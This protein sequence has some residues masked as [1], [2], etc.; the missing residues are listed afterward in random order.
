MEPV[1]RKYKDNP[2]FLDT[3]AWLDYRM[4]DYRSAKERLASL[5]DKK[6]LLPVINYHLGMICYRLGEE[7]QARKYLDMAINAERDFP[8][9]DVALMVLEGLNQRR[10]K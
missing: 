7:N 8:G 6:G 4:G 10:D 5:K 3:M 1:L 9:K 2:N